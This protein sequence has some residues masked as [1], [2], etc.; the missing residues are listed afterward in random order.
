MT[1]LGMALS[2]PLNGNRVP[3]S[4]MLSLFHLYLYL[5]NHSLFLSL[6]LYQTK[7]SVGTPLPTVEPRIVPEG[8]QR[9]LDEETINGEGVVGE[10]Q[11]RGPAVFKG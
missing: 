6:D 7:G 8:E 9:S 11:I 4:I 2:N 3:V 1:E 10:L 5:T